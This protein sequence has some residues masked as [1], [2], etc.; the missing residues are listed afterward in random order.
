M[1]RLLDV[2]FDDEK[3]G[4]LSRDDTGALGF[5]YQQ[6]GTKDVQLSTVA[7]L[8]HSLETHPKFGHQE[9]SPFSF[10]S[11]RPIA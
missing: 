4:T 2:R 6:V 11:R 8:A 5:A 3:A 9:F 10:C 7:T 1:T